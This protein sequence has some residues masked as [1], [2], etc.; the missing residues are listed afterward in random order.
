MPRIQLPTHHQDT[1][2]SGRSNVA[3][4]AW[5]DSEIPSP[6]LVRTETVTTLPSYH[7]I[8][9]APE[10]TAQ[11]SNANDAVQE[12]S[13]YYGSNDGD[14]AAET[15]FIAE[16]RATNYTPQ[17]EH[18]QATTMAESTGRPR[19]TTSNVSQNIVFEP[20]SQHS[21]ESTPGL[22]ITCSGSLASL[23]LD[24]IEGH[25]EQKE[26]RERLEDYEASRSEA[27]RR[28]RAEMDRLNYLVET[29]SNASDSEDDSRRQPII[30]AIYT[31]RD[32]ITFL[33]ESCLVWESQVRSRREELTS[34]EREQARIVH[35][36]FDQA[37]AAMADN[38]SAPEDEQQEEGPENI[39]QAR[40]RDE[41]IDRSHAAIDEDALASGEEQP[42]TEAQAK[43]EVSPSPIQEQWF[44]NPPSSISGSS[45][46]S[47]L[48]LEALH[49]ANIIN[50]LNDTFHRPMELHYQ[51]HRHNH[52]RA[53]S[54]SLGQH[55]PVQTGIRPTTESESDFTIFAIGMHLARQRDQLRMT[56]TEAK[57]RAHLLGMGTRFYR[58]L[59][60]LEE[61]T[62]I[63][64]FDDPEYG[65]PA[66]LEVELCNMVDRAQIE[67]WMENIPAH[68]VSSPAEGEYG[69]DVVGLAH[70][71]DGVW[72]CESV[73]DVSD[74]VSVRAFGRQRTRI[75]GWGQLREE[76]F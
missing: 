75:D 6:E 41:L 19:E 63:F 26:L 55:A 61:A 44:T 76:S 66:S 5:D 54:D 24:V 31:G 60:E 1:L 7:I 57:R 51:I 39:E 50:E 12:S 25:R 29:L 64:D 8:T 17:P 33:E 56:L 18:G 67:S 20:T 70:D 59:T 42:E 38:T 48:S 13:S 27:N 69:E 45:S 53:F 2:T 52:H 28:L 3:I 73:V 37:C 74:S 72:E 23:L 43:S 9:P 65:Y 32:R 71:T 16:P 22:E 15:S 40:L 10:Y 68:E 58:T 30:Q 14:E 47:V 49:R 62:A 21:N 46:P 11:F 35:Q 34:A 36:F 4:Y